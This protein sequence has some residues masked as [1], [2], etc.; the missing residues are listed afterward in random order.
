MMINLHRDADAVLTQKEKEDR[1]KARMIELDSVGV[2]LG[3]S[4]VL[5]LA[6]GSMSAT[7]NNISV[8]MR[9]LL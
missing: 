1:I 7:A 8:S 9:K 3:T 2:V 6:F 5:S 4:L